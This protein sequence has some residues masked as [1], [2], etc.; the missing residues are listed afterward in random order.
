M[1]KGGVIVRRQ[2]PQKCELPIISQREGVHY[3]ARLRCRE[4]QHLTIL[5]NKTRTKRISCRYTIHPQKIRYY[6]IPACTSI[7][8]YSKMLI[9]INKRG[10]IFFP[11]EIFPLS[12]YLDT[13]RL[14]T[15]LFLHGVIYR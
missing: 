12:I 4:M 15:A 2:V 14:C 1:T 3:L 8:S 11:S 9:L 10:T 7:F 5:T 6:V 13:L